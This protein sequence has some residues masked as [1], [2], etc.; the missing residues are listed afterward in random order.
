MPGFSPRTPKKTAAV[1]VSNKAFGN[2]DFVLTIDC[3]ADHITIFPSGIQYRW[4]DQNTRETDQ[5]VVQ[6]IVKLVERRQASVR[7]GE[8]PY[9]PTIRF[10]VSPSGLRSYYHVYPLLEHL[11]IPWT[12]E[13]VED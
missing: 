2:R 13:N 12:R 10:Q 7:Q 4:K 3:Y 6:T 9:R 8:P 11:H 1:S 5:A